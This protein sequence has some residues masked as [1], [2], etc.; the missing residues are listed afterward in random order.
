MGNYKAMSNACACLGAR[1]TINQNDF[2]HVVDVESLHPILIP[3]CL[4]TVQIILCGK[5]A[6]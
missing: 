4:R 6:G 5:E 1:A 3:K 2:N